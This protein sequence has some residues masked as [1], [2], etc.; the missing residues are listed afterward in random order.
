MY[1]VLRLLSW[2]IILTL[3]AQ[4]LVAGEPDSSESVAAPEIAWLDSYPRA[5]DQAKAE[6]KMMLVY[7]QGSDRNSI[8]DRFE[9]ALLNERVAELVNKMV[10]V[11]VTPDTEITVNG[12]PVRL[13]SHQAFEELGRRQ[14]IAIV[15]MAHPD[16]EHYGYVVTAVPFTRGKY[17]EFRPDHLAVVL[18][19]PAGTITQRTLVFA[20]RIHPESPASTG[21]VNDP[22]LT[23]EARSHSNHQARIRLQGHHAWERRFHRIR[24]L[25]PF[26]GSPTEVCA[27]SWPNESLLDAAVDVVDSWR[28]SSGHWNAVRSRQVRFGYDMKRGSNGI[29]YATGIFGNR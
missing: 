7:F 25:L 26:G 18:D 6:R 19:L 12:Q 11:R 20:V 24:G 5:M 28:H 21:G 2:S 1:P 17:Y 10:A 22:I 15:D 29:W 16:T 4:S 23:S 27:E 3:G 14:G 9:N 8:R 13:L